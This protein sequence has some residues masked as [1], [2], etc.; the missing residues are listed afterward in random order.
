MRLFLATVLLLGTTTICS[1]S[2]A[3]ERWQA[4]R[5]ANAVV[6][7]FQDDLNKEARENIRTKDWHE[8]RANIVAAILGNALLDASGNVDDDSNDD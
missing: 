5:L 3:Q 6:H 1:A 8:L 2:T 7:L 4:R